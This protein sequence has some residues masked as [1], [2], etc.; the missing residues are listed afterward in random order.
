MSDPLEEDLLGSPP[1]PT[2]AS[3]NNNNNTEM[4]PLSIGES[5]AETT[6][7]T[8]APAPNLATSPRRGSVARSAAV[9][10]D[11]TANCVYCGIPMG[12]FLAVPCAAGMLHN[13]CVYPYERSQRERCAFCNA[14]L[15]DKRV[16]HGGKKIHPECL[17]GAKQGHTFVPA[18]LEGVAKKFAIGRSFF[19][20]KNWKER[21]FVLAAGGGAEEGLKYYESE[22]DAKSNKAPKGMVKIKRPLPSVP[23]EGVPGQQPRLVTKPTRRQHP[24]AENPSKELLIIF[25]EDGKERKL[26]MSC[27]SWDEQ[28]TWV[29]ALEHFIHNVDDPKD[30]KD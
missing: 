22:A 27:R 7:T 15:R 6:T 18:T 8:T 30:Y 5:S 10:S 20:G 4:D 3:S 24:E 11:P 2:P 25:Y 29:K 9:A 13:E 21:Y 28:Q 26:L 14:L 16:L 23:M 1:K 19:G 12:N 17:A